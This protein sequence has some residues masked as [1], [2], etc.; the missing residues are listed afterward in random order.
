MWESDAPASATAWTAVMDALA[1]ATSSSENLRSKSSES[2]RFP[3]RFQQCKLGL[4][5]CACCRP[6]GPHSGLESQRAESTREEGETL[7]RKKRRKRSACL[8]QLTA[9]SARQTIGESSS[10]FHC[11]GGIQHSTAQSVW[12]CLGSVRGK[13]SKV[14]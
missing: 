10:S 7:Q 13:L 14:A 11:G 9:G 1:D 5:C 4:L 3:K 12:K 8:S 2:D 6:K